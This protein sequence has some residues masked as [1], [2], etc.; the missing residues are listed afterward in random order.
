MLGRKDLQ[1]RAVGESFEIL[2]GGKTFSYLWEQEK[3]KSNFTWQDRSKKHD[4]FEAH[5]F[6]DQL[7]AVAKPTSREVN[8]QQAIEL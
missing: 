7:N 5:S 8:T 2:V 1:I 4:A 3:Q 6:G